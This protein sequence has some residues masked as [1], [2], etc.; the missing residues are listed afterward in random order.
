MP[1]HPFSFVE[2]DDGRLLMA[3]GIDPMLSWDGVNPN[4]VRAGVRP[5]ASAPTLTYGNDSAH[6][7]VIE[8]E[9]DAYVRFQDKSGAWSN[10]SPISSTVTVQGTTGHVTGI[11]GAYLET[12]TVHNLGLNSE[13]TIVEQIRSSTP[14]AYA[15]IIGTWTVAPTS[16]VNFVLLNEYGGELFSGFKPGAPYITG[17]GLKFGWDAKASFITYTG[18]TNAGSDGIDPNVVRRQILRNT[19]GQRDVYYVD[20]DTTDMGSST[21]TSYKGD[22]ELS[23]QEAVPL[24]DAT[25][26]VLAN[27]FGYPPS[28]KAALVYHLDRIYAAVN[29][30]YRT[31]NAAMTFGSTT[32]TGIGTDWPT[33]FAG[34]F[35]TFAGGDKAYEINSV[36]RPTQIMTLAEAYS[37]TTS[38]YAA[39]VI[40]SAPAERKTVRYSEA[41]LPSAWPAT[42]SLSVQNDGDDITGL[43]TQQSFLYILER[44]HIYRLAVQEDP[45]VDGAVYPAGDRGCI[46]NR[47]WVL[48]D[49]TAY[50][51]DEKGV[52]SFSGNSSQD[53]SLP[54][55]SLFQTSLSTSPYRINWHWKASR[56]FHAI[57]DPQDEVIRWFVSLGSSYMPRHALC[58]NYRGNRW[59]IERYP[60]S[61]GGTCRGYLAG[62][63]QVYAGAPSRRVLAL[64]TGTLDGAIPSLGTVRGTCTAAGFFTLTD[65]AAAFSS[66][67]LTGVPVAIY[68]GTGKGQVRIIASNTSTVLTLSHP[69][70]VLPDSTSEYQIGG[71]Q[72][73]YR[74]RWHRFIRDEDTAPRR[75]EL[76]FEPAIEE[77]VLDIRMFRDRSTDPLIWDADVDANAGGGI[78]SVKGDP[79][80]T[81]DLTKPIGHVQTRMDHHK[82]EYTDGPRY[83]QIEMGGVAN[84]DRVQIYQILLDGLES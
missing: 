14:S 67:K 21:F 73:I 34:R 50:L 6:A 45:A 75:L 4:V 58:F 23:E 54:I 59:W 7:G 76:V 42:N 53:V 5:P 77:A 57:H 70:I 81:A 35:I 39:Y 44:R 11:S 64:A 17:L 74:T 13:V 61:V 1:T 46:N 8:G 84:Q 79:Y 12:G 3:N 29:V 9:Y 27:R 78:A 24:L 55:R 65:S 38:T 69:W 72:W 47:C 10:L 40:T 49:N 37:G 60:V 20:I 32:V 56:W 33:N 82:E 80:L 41:A 28:N 51:L 15:Y 43:M 68:A 52:Y 71:I 66:T 16:T 48:V 25:G 18:V 19:A 31:G 62:R 26:A 2:T 36:V 30:P 63:P 83:L 22:D